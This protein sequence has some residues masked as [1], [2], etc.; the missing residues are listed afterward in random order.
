M[1]LRQRRIPL[2]YSHSK[3]SFGLRL[4]AAGAAATTAVTND[5]QFFVLCE[6]VGSFRWMTYIDSYLCNK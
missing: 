1:E 5:G 4:A 2:A 3:P 6:H